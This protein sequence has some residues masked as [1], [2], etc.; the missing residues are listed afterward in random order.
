MLI[1]NFSHV[2]IK[3][4]ALLTKQQFRKHT[5]F[6]RNFNLGINSWCF[7][8]ENSEIVIGDDV[9]CRGILRCEEYSSGKIEIGNNVYIGDDCILSCANT[10]KIGQFTLLAHGVQIFDNNSHPILPKDRETDWLIVTTRL[11]ENRTKIE[12]APIIIGRNCWIGMNSIIMKGVTIG[13]NSIVASGSIVAKNVPE[14]VIVAGNPAVI[15][16][17]INE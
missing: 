14:N 17:N 2:K 13:N 12:H 4:Y 3:I 16:K 5:K 8:H 15:V 1:W 11:S 9:V 6:G 10:I 7:R